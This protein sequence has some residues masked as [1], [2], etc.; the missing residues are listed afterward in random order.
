MSCG[1]GIVRGP[2][3]PG[4]VLSCLIVAGVVLLGGG[5]V[6]GSFCRGC[7]CSGETAGVVLSGV[8]CR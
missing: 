8:E 6:R 5:I 4:V 7:F 2:F 1:G 3:C